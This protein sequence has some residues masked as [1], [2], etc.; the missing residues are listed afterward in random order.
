MFGLLEPSPAWKVP[1]WHSLP[2]S[3]LHASFLS[4]HPMTMGPGSFQKPSP[5]P[6][7]FILLALE[8]AGDAKG[9][10]KFQR[11]C[12][13]IS[14]FTPWI[15]VY[16][17]QKFR[18]NGGDSI[19]SSAMSPVE[20]SVCISALSLKDDKGSWE[21]ME[22]QWASTECPSI[23]DYAKRQGICVDTKPSVGSLHEAFRQW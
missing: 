10:L 13:M 15:L 14:T 4:S 18:G 23:C 17:L 21:E 20:M 22:L 12:Q 16:I 6:H 7:L 3:F 1:L 19:K 2:L 11:L 9:G 5:H 8:R